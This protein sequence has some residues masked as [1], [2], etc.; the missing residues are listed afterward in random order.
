ML[1]K[2]GF[3]IFPLPKN[4]NDFINVPHYTIGKGSLDV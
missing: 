4:V 1:E 3:S 2:M